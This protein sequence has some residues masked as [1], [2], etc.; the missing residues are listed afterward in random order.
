[1]D[2]AEV[3]AERLIRE[4][5]AKGQFDRLKGSGKPIADLDEYRE[6][7]WWAART[8]AEERRRND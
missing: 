2:I 3:I 6:P 4:A 8:I 5:M 1:M 7:G